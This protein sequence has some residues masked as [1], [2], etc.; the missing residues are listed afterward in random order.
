MMLVLCYV[1]LCCYSTDFI[2]RPLAM[3]APAFPAAFHR[4]MM[5]VWSYL[6]IRMWK[7]KA[8]F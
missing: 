6:L 5:N 4:N 3:I 7:T 8:Y 1:L 2:N